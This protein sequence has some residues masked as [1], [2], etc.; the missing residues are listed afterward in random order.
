MP[1]PHD[2]WAAVYDRVNRSIFGPTYDRLTEVTVRAIQAK[3]Q[4]SARVVDFGAGT[5]RLSIPLR[6]AGYTVESVEPSQP[7]C[8]I[9]AANAGHR[10]GNGLTIR[11]STAAGYQ[12]DGGADLDLCVFTVLVYLTDEEALTETV[13]AVAKSLKPGGHL[14]IDIPTQHLFRGYDF[15]KE[16]VARDVRITPDPEEKDLYHY[17]D[18][19]EVDGESYG[20]EF[21]IRFWPREKVDHTL[22]AAGLIPQPNPELEKSLVFSGASYLWYRKE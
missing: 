22:Q 18:S 14:L 9:L 8:D 13:G 20:D 7:M 10:F 5:G 4:P 11:C 19:I 17:V 16:G 6:D 2:S 1:L 12:G 15:R 21:Q 3:K